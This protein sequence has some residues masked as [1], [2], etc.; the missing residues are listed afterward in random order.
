MNEI[1]KTPIP[2]QTQQP[3]KIEQVKPEANQE[4]P[5][6]V[7]A[8]QTT[9][10]EINEIP[11]NPADRS[12]VKVDN[13]ENDIKTFVSDPDLAS[14]AMEIAELAENRYKDAGVENPQAKALN[15]AQAFVEEFQK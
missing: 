1:P 5:V 13:I 15:V 4:Q 14:K 9:V 7:P 2:Q 3:Q 12:G 11:D 10:K 6:E 8:A